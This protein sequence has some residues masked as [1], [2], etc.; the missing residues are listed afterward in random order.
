VFHAALTGSSNRTLLPSI[1]ASLPFS[2]VHRA[3][4][5]RRVCRPGRRRVQ[6][7]WRRSAMKLVSIALI[8]AGVIGLNLSGVTP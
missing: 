7:R 4:V 8:L 5:R 2:V 3:Q 6:I 1:A